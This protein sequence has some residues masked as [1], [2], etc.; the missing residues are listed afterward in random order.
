MTSWIDKQGDV[1]TEGDDGLLHTPET[2]PFPRAYVE[3]KWGPLLEVRLCERCGE[4]MRKQAG[5]AIACGPDG[6]APVDLPVTWSCR[7]AECRRAGQAERDAAAIARAV[8]SG[9][10]D[11]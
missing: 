11:P 10:I 1:W 8:A 3:H 9:L 7:D 6:V 4:P 2:A 5:F